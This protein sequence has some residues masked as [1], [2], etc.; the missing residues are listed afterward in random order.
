MNTSTKII[1]SATAAVIVTTFAAFTTYEGSLQAL[2]ENFPDVDPKIARKVHYE[3]CKETLFG[4]Y[5]GKTD[6]ETLN[7]LFLAKVQEL[8]QK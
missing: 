8:T 5:E 3:M 6:D 4:K 7:K 1:L 2:M